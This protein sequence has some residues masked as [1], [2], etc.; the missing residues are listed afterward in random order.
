MKF[1]ILIVI[2]TCLLGLQSAFSA[3]VSTKYC[4][5]HKRKFDKKIDYRVSR[6]DYT[7]A[8]GNLLKILANEKCLKAASAG[9]AISDFKQI[10]KNIGSSYCEELVDNMAVLLADDLFGDIASN[11]D[12]ASELI[13]DVDELC[14]E[15]KAQRASVLEFEVELKNMTGIEL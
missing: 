3:E 11:S 10:F 12:E 14:Q 2:F 9:L 4:N 7:P 8:R 15:F 6:G 5:G 1:Q 13:E